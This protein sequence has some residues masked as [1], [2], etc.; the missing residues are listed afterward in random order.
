MI[1]AASCLQNIGKGLNRT[2][3]KDE[4]G[5]IALASEEPPGEDFVLLLPAEMMG[6]HMH[7]KRWSVSHA[8][9]SVSRGEESLIC[10]STTL[11]LQHMR[12]CLEP[13]CL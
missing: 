4:L 5:P 10:R 1:D 3:L 7:D 2:Q 9:P 8:L 11:S 6:F 13:R 12:C